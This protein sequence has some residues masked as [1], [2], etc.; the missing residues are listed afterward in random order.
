MRATVWELL[1]GQPAFRGHQFGF[2]YE[3][4]G[5]L[6]SAPTARSST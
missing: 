3:Q 6:D 5:V 4:V 2:I 1:V